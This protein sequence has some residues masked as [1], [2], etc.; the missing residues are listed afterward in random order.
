MSGARSGGCGAVTEGSAGGGGDSS[1]ER[2]FPPRTLIR[3]HALPM[4]G[5]LAAAPS[6]YA[7]P[8]ARST[9][10]VAHDHRLRSRLSLS[11][12]PSLGTIVRMPM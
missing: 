12:I 3:S 1:V 6:A 5:G 8:L 11:T 4:K 7:A 10:G 9:D 2:R